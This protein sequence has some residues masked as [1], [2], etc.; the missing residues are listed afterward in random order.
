MQISSKPEGAELFSDPLESTYLLRKLF[1]MPS[2]QGGYRGVA[3]TDRESFYLAAGYAL[4]ITAIFGFLWQFATYFALVFYPTEES[5]GATRKSVPAESNNPIQ[6]KKDKD[7][8]DYYGG[9]AELLEVRQRKANRYIAL[10]AIWNSSDPYT[11]LMLLFKHFRLI[12]RLDK[13]AGLYDGIMMLIAL[14]LVVGGIFAGIVVPAN[15]EMGNVAP[16]NPQSVFFAVPEIGNYSQS[17]MAQKVTAPAA[18]RAVGVVEYAKTQLRERV[19]FSGISSYEFNVSGVDFGLQLR[20]ALDFRVHTTG[21]CVFNYTAYNTTDPVSDSWD[22]Y[23]V[24]GQEYTLLA[25]Q[26]GAS[27]GGRIVMPDSRMFDIEGQ[28]SNPEVGANLSYTIIPDTAGRYSYTQSTDEWYRTE[29]V[30]QETIYQVSRGRPVLSCW[31]KDEWSYKG[32]T[33]NLWNLDQLGVDIPG[34]ILNDF[35]TNRFTLP[36]TFTIG[37]ALGPALLS[38]SAASS[39]GQLDAQSASHIVDFE[40][41]VLGAYVATQDVL[42]DSTM[43][44]GLGLG[45]R[46]RA[47]DSTGT[48][49]NGIGHFVI[50]STKVKALSLRVLVSVPAIWAFL[51]A[52]LSL[53]RYARPAHRNSGK[54]SR[55]T[56]R[57]TALQAMQLYRMLDEEK[58]GNRDDWIG[59]LDDIPYIK[60]AKEVRREL[61]QGTSEKPQNGTDA[62]GSHRPCLFIA[63]KVTQSTVP[64]AS[65]RNHLSFMGPARYQ[66]HVHDNKERPFVFGATD[67]QEVADGP[68]PVVPGGGTPNE[69]RE[70]S[71][72]ISPASPN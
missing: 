13:R 71:E 41:L 52:A 42:R 23:V 30:P 65:R 9:S 63:P 59:R 69:K 18:Q 25:I 40:R 39:G 2:T 55:F 60:E 53:T 37:M 15:L 26:T 58:C 3:L 48:P 66:P 72:T 64:G 21:G 45:I 51:F 5:R 34:I 56:L 35:F 29:P 57:A 22:R 54:M 62:T 16:A 6:A 28:Y 38:D 49:I 7:F 8:S 47:H 27:V 67:D 20:D 11:A 17:L 33:R 70:L 14:I 31:Q 68:E 50:S 24:Y 19:N 44:G 61:A 32:K 4:L 36:M 46:N 43:S 1:I 10:I 12:F